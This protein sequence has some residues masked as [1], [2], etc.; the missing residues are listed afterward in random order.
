MSRASLTPRARD[1]LDYITEYTRNNRGVSPS[2]DQM[3][4][5]L[6]LKSKNSVHRL[7]GQIEERGHITRLPHRSRSIAIRGVSEDDPELRKTLLLIRRTAECGLS[8]M[9]G[10][11]AALRSILSMIDAAEPVT[12]MR[13][14]GG[15][16]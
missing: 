15:A 2:Y 9:H 6:G 7:I 1:L 3:A 14:Q 8:D 12:P 5:R 13:K 10:K 11:S 16:A 4:A